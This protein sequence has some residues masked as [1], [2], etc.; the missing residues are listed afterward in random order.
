[1]VLGLSDLME[2]T[3]FQIPAA[4]NNVRLRLRKDPLVQANFRHRVHELEKELKGF[5][6][7]P[8]HIYQELRK[9]LKRQDVNQLDITFL[10]ASKTKRLSV[11]ITPDRC[12]NN[13]IGS[14]LKRHEPRTRRLSRFYHDLGYPSLYVL[15]RPGE[16]EFLHLTD[17]LLNKDKGGHVLTIDY[18]AS[19]EPLSHSLSVDPAYDG[20]FVP[21]IPHHLMAELPH[22][23]GDWTVCAGHIDWTTFVDFTNLAAVGNELGYETL[24][25]GPQSF[26]EQMTS[27]IRP[28]PA[29][30]GDFNNVNGY[31]L[32]EQIEW[33]GRHT[34]NWYGPEK[35]EPWEQRWTGFKALLRRVPPVQDRQTGARCRSD[36]NRSQALTQG[37]VHRMEHPE[38]IVKAPTW[39]LDSLESDPCWVFDPTDMPI[40]D[41]VR[42]NAEATNAT[43]RQ[44]LGTLTVDVDRA[45]GVRY[46]SGYEEAQLSVHLVDFLVKSVGCL[47]LLRTD[48]VSKQW[49]DW[50]KVRWANI[51]KEEILDKVGPAVMQVLSEEAAAIG[52]NTTA[53][54]KHYP[55]ECM[56]RQTFRILCG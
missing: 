44:I 1:M 36:T 49:N 37:T 46:A 31:S 52:S 17:C 6:A 27:A 33:V 16:E 54:V 29:M 9:A 39:H 8:R 53:K 5:L 55:Y 45:L 51:W 50:Y 43:R 38:T 18:G 32:L 23:H 34:T 21:P 28:S 14:F 10:I 40:A 20:I 15:M 19:F 48:T 42:I 2:M 25:Y 4:S 35:G 7:I 22:C 24:F 26:L 13:G 3:K 47:A 56:A 12:K 11:P 30:E 41:W